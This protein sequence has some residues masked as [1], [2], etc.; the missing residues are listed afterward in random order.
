MDIEK[1]RLFDTIAITWACSHAF[2]TTD[3]K[4]GFS[5]ALKVLTKL[6]KVSDD[7]I[8]YP[9]VGNNGSNIHFHGVIK[10]NDKVKWFKSVLPTLKRNGFVKITTFNDAWIDY[11]KKDWDT[12]K[13]VLDLEA[14]ITD[15]FIKQIIQIRKLKDMHTSQ[16]IVDMMYKDQK[17]H[18]KYDHDT[19]CD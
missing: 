18:L 4:I 19:D 12:M 3:L 10:L 11:I 14:P 7:F 13:Q 17:H 16:N 15:G 2:H 9:E 8:L 5:M 6:N 1:K